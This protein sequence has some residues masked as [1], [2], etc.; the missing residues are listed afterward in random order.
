MGKK[1]RRARGLR[2]GAAAIPRSGLKPGRSPDKGPALN[3][4]L[5]GG[6]GLGHK[7]IV[8]QRGQNPPD[9]RPQD[10]EPGAR[11]V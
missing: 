5:S 6:F 10:V 8:E 7:A 9:D 1:A 3:G 11:E 4:G 2:Q